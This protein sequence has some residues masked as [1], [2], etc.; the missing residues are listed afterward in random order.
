MCSCV[1]SVAIPPRGFNESNKFL[2][3]SCFTNRC[4]MFPLS[5]SLSMTFE[6]LSHLMYTHTL[7]TF[8]VH[9]YIHLAWWCVMDLCE[10]SVVEINRK[11]VLNILHAIG[12]VCEILS[13]DGLRVWWLHIKGCY[14]CNTKC[15]VLAC[16]TR[17]KIWA[18]PWNPRFE[19]EV[20]NTLTTR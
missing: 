2:R 14:V 20:F 4:W 13:D 11:R 18:I 1:L 3:M 16:N 17:E 15:I 12:Y 5:S 10:W 19:V 8:W 7:A 6:V 9:L